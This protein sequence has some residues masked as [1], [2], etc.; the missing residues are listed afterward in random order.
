MRV[1]A[2]YSSRAKRQ[3]TGQAPLSLSRATNNRGRGVEGEEEAEKWE[4]KKWGTGRKG[5]VVVGGGGE[6]RVKYDSGIREIWDRNEGILWPR[7]PCTG[8]K[9]YLVLDW[10]WPPPFWYS[11]S[12]FHHHYLFFFFFFS[13]FFLFFLLLL[14]LLLV[15]AAEVGASLR[16]ASP[17]FRCSVVGSVGPFAALSFLVGGPGVP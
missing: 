7:G 17:L 14:L 16:N 13:C 6:Q 8:T 2:R 1:A 3:E 12:A 9:A 10:T 15:V 4:S 11:T 5:R